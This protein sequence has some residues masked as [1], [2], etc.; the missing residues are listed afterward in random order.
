MSRE[1]TVPASIVK[2]DIYLI[3][4]AVGIAV[5]VVVGFLNSENKFDLAIPTKEYRILGNDYQ[6][7]VGGPTNWA[8]DKPTGTYRN[9]DLWHYIDLQRYANA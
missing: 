8:T 7:L 9:E 2:E 6:E 3:E 1:V 5:R 4:E